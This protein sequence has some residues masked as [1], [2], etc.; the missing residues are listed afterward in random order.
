VQ[1]ENLASIKVLQKNGIYKEGFFE[2]ISENRRT[3]ARPRAL[4]DNR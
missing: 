1:Q 4:G 3:L 2:Q